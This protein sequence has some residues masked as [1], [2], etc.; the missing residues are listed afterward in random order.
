MDD[1]IRERLASAGMTPA[2]AGAKAV[3][4]ARATD[5]L[6]AMRPATSDAFA[7][8]VPGRVEFLGKHTD[9]AGGRSLLCTVERG[10]CLVSAPRDDA[11]IRITDVSLGDSATFAMDPELHPP[12]GHWSNYPMTVARRLARNFPGARRG[13]DIALASDLPLASGISSS[14]AFVVAVFL[15]LAAANALDG[16]SLFRAEVPDDIA[17]ASYLGCVENGQSF[18]ALAGDRGVGVFGGSEDQTAILCCRPGMLSQYSFCPVRGEGAVPFPP[19]HVLAIANS[20]VI[21]E[22]AGAARD[23]YNRASL[24]TRALVE[25]WNEGTGRTD[26]VLA[27]AI[28]S[29]PDAADRLR[30]MAASWT[31][32]AFPAEYL[33]N[34]LD[35]FVDESTRIIPAVR[36]ALEHGDLA[37]V[38]ALVAGSQANA[39]SLLGNQVPETVAL[40]QMAREAGAVAASAFGAGFGGSVW[41]L[42]QA[43]DADAWAQ[44]WLSRYGRAFPAAA[45]R[46]SVFV[47]PAGPPAVRL[48]RVAPLGGSAPGAHL[49]A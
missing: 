27:D 30:A 22:K 7:F 31:D 1:M 19:G 43:R 16:D 28:G 45:V 21:A 20:G 4:F 35:Q 42:V 47:T 48:G 33:V 8:W 41:A 32:G 39:E 24:S 36:A 26:A 29:A 25:R 6:R 12:I 3:L 18:G 10:I 40:V 13:A 9:Y 2:A 14:S 11:T 38:G 15:A 17:L 46:A 23:A 34:R 49:G 5:A 44:E 37:R